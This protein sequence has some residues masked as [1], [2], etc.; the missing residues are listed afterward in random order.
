MKQ[1]SHMYACVPTSC[2]L[3]RSFIS[4]TDRNDFVK[5]VVLLAS[6]PPKDAY[7]SEFDGMV[8]NELHLNGEE[9]IMPE[10]PLVNW[11]APISLGSPMPEE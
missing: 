3:T 4:Q 6:S 11:L 10:I 9:V 1:S 2:S 7:F 5:K 8:T